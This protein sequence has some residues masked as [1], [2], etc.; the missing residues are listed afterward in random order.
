MTETHQPSSFQLSTEQQTSRAY[1][2]LQLEE[3]SAG[4]YPVTAITE[5]YANGL[6]YPAAVIKAS[7]PLWESVN[8][9]V[10][11]AGP[12][13]WGRPGGR[14]IRDLAGV[15]HSV[16][17]DEAQQG[18]RGKVKLLARARWLC[19]IIAEC[20]AL[21]A[22]AEPTPHIGLSAD[23]EVE[24]RGDQVTAINKVY[25]LDVVMNPARGGSIEAALAQS[26]P[27]PALSLKGEGSRTE[28]RIHP[29][30][31]TE[32]QSVAAGFTP[33]PTPSP[34]GR[35]A[36]SEP[37]LSDVGEGPGGEVT[38]SR[39]RLADELESFR[40]E[41]CRAILAVKLAESRLPQ[42]F[43]EQ[44]LARWQDRT[45]AIAEL[46]A[47]LR[48]TEAALARFM[49]NRTIQHLGAVQQVVTP[50][51]RLQL[52]LERLLGL[53]IPDSASDIPRLSG[54]R[55]FYLTTTGDWEMSGAFRPER[56]Q[57]ANLTTT[58]L[59]SMVKNALNKL[60]LQAYEARPFWWKP[61]VWEEDFN[62]LNDVTWIT[63][64]GFADLPTVAEGAEYTELANL[65]DIEETSSFLKKGAYSAITLEAIDRDDIALIKAL[66]RKLGLAANRTLSSAISAI[67]TANSGVGPPLGQDSTA[68]FH[69]NHANLG[70]TAL[71]TTS[72]DA[73]VQAM[74]KQTEPASGKRLGLRP[75]Y[76]IVPIE[77]E[78]TARQILESAEFTG[79]TTTVLTVNPRYRSAGVVVVPEFTDAN[80][81]AACANP[82]DAP[83]I[84]VGYRN[85]R[86]PELFIAQD[87]LT[88]SMF[89]A[90][91]MRIKVRFLYTVGIG[92]YRALYKANVA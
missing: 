66:P 7:L 4:E 28:R 46:E 12:A 20:L 53:P 21:K 44:I 42:P 60:L 56:V 55:E 62:T 88:G 10:D 2:A 35:E 73:C 50:V 43:K 57:L 89:T 90:D 48:S 63:A 77:L 17:W 1:L 38:I 39:V 67:F 16:F 92:E 80:D 15:L 70:S 36:A 79:G 68:L 33:A 59:T 41:S 25:S 71:S 78:Y 14:S 24:R 85:G 32:I 47:D 54:F 61:I 8:V 6:Y 81:W 5:G 22:A 87:P 13:D 51:D 18:I 9:F 58:T 29:M 3:A 76:L 40:K 34:S 49:E 19:E 45:F 72:W 31:T 83:G 37:P 86:A 91:T 11:H 52:A 30:E 69:S 75:A 84:C 65:T 27:H 64:G 26:K 82:Q 23:L 74:F